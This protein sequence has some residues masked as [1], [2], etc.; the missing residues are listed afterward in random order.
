MEYFYLHFKC[1]P[2]PVS[3]PKTPIPSPYSFFYEVVVPPQAPLFPPPR[4]DIP[5]FGKTK[6]FS[7][8]WCPTRPSSATYAA[9]AMNLS[10]YTLW[11]VVYS[12]G[13]LV[14]WY[15]CSY[16]VANPFSSFSSF[17]NPSNSFFNSFNR[18]PILSSMV[19]C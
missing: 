13:V 6:G 8:H 12:L 4:P 16:G 9:G 2:F 11:V 14:G 19:C 5:S 15:C 1:Y 17:F 10:I 7:S 18:D 3:H